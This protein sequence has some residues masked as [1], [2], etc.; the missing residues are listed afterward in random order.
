MKVVTIIIF[1]LVIVIS[2]LVGHFIGRRVVPANHLQFI[3]R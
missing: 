3:D 1:V 2:I